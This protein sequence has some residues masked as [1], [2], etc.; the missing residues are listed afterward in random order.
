MIVSTR[1][2]ADHLRD[3]DLVVLAVGQKADYDAGHIP[4]SRFID[5]ASIRTAGGADALNTELP[6]MANLAAAFGKLGV[7]NNSRIVLY[8]LTDSL[9]PMAR[10]YLTLDAMGLGANAS[11]LD[12]SLALWK[13]ENRPVTR[14]APAVTQGKIDPCPQSDVIAN[15]DYVRSHLRTPG[16]AIV[17]ARLPQFYSGA[18][19]GQRGRAGHIPGAGSLPFSSLVEDNGKLKSLPAL[20]ELFRAAGAKPG[21]RVVSY[22]HVGQQA[23][24]VYFV[25]RY[26]GYDARMYDGSMD[27][28]SRHDDLPVEK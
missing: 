28:W 2:L 25:A 8:M 5:L 14:E 11:I 16:A 12:G 23:S 3:P 17:D 20:E 15:L 6:P 4:D 10:V 18:Q 9:S 19:P 21:D 7:S 26:L 24:V 13:A 1:W 27:E 22:C